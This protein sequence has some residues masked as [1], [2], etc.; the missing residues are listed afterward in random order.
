MFGFIS[1][2]IPAGTAGKKAAAAPRRGLSQSAS[3]T[4]MSAITIAILIGLLALGFA[5]RLW[6]YFPHGIAR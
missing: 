1:T 5:I 2:S 4:T 6:I 3:E